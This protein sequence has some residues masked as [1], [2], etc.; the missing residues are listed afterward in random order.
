M[1][2]INYQAFLDRYLVI[3]IVRVVCLSQF[4]YFECLNSLLQKFLSCESDLC[5]SRRYFYEHVKD[6]VAS[7]AGAKKDRKGEGDSCEERSQEGYSE[8]QVTGMIKWGQKL[9]PQKILGS[10]NKPK[11]IPGP[12]LNPEKNL[13]LNFRALKISRKDKM[14]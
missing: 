11:K 4:A 6:H 13:M 9:G 3:F 14:I 1:H 5:F 7:V 12:K 8:L 10:S 2:E